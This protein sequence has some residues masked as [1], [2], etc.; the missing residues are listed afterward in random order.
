MLNPFADKEMGA[1]LSLPSS[2]HLSLELDADEGEKDSA[3]GID[4]VLAVNLEKTE[5][6]DNGPCPIG[7]PLSRFEPH[8]RQTWY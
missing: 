4:L 7:G 8:F 3:L 2:P 5:D 6:T 1:P